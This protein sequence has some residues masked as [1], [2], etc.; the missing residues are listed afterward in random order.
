MSTLLL[1]IIFALLCGTAG[2]WLRQNT[3]LSV[4]EVSALLALVAGLVL[5][6]LFTEGALFALVC[7]AVSYATMCNSKRVCNYLEMLIVSGI[8]ALVVFFGQN[9]LVGV[10]GRLG[11]SA[12]ISVL[13]FV[14]A[15][16]LFSLGDN[17]GVVSKE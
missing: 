12:A 5:P 10:G 9:V 13:I 3:K 4:V 6:R 2:F 16:S 7:T 1:S 17:K 8:C 15:K 14:L 11:T